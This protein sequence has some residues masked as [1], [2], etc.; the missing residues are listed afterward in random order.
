[1]I[2]LDNTYKKKNDAVRLI[3]ESEAE[4]DRHINEIA[5]D[6]CA[7]KNLRCV[8]LAGPTCSGKTTTASKLTAAMEKAG[9]RARVVTID[10]FYFEK[11]EMEERGLTD[12]EGPTA[13]NIP[14]FERAAADL[15]AGRATLL[16]TFDFTDRT[17][18]AFTEYT[19]TPDDIYI[20]EGI[21]AIYPEITSVLEK[22]SFRSIFIYPA[23]DIE[24]AGIRFEKNEIR[25]IRR[26]V[27]DMNHRSTAPAETMGLWSAVRQNEEI[28]IFPL[29]G[30]ENYVIN[31]TVAYELLLMGKY[32]LGATNGYTLD[33]PYAGT[34]YSLRE[35]IRMISD[36]A[37]NID[38]VPLTSVMREFAD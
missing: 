23:T 22:F 28:N 38:M 12:I 4:F 6:I 24:I 29:V 14:L 36:T 9:R 10:D 7:D 5:E 13:L 19:P 1:M 31:S 21:Q 17:R 32:F 8:T 16:P 3:S 15:A 34:V 2:I 25:L 18:A 30:H 26:I 33:A 11:M 35:R 27:R 37:V 20:F